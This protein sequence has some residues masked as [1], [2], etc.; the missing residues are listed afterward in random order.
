MPPQSLAKESDYLHAW[1]QPNPASNSLAAVP[2]SAAPAHVC[3]HDWKVPLLFSQ[4]L[5]HKAMLRHSGS[6]RQVVIEPQQLADAQASAAAERPA[7]PA[8]SSTAGH[9]L[10]DPLLPLLPLLLEDPLLPL[11]ESPLLLPPLLELLVETPLLLPEEPLELLPPLL[12]PEL[13]LLEVWPLLLP[14]LADAS[15]V[16]PSVS[17]PL[18]VAPEQ[19][20]TPKTPVASVIPMMIKDSRCMRASG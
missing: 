4:V 3:A 1:R 17:S 8:T 19:P 9:P 13:P 12:A 7:G 10:L 2:P 6:S 5:T 18:I 16:P 11:L 14:L 15:F 20:W